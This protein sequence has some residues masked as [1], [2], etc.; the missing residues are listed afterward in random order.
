[1]KVAK[2][3]PVFMYHH[4]S[5]APGLVTVSPEN[6][7]AQ[8]ESLSRTGWRTAGLDELAGFLKGYPVPDRTCILTFDD[9]YRDNYVHA[10]PVLAEFGMKA[11]LFLITG[12][13]GQGAPRALAMPPISHAKCMASATDG[14]FSEIMLRWSEAEQMAKAGTFEFH[15]HTHTHKRWDRMIPEV[16]ERLAQLRNDLI[17]SRCTLERHLGIT[18]PH[19]CWPQ[20]YYDSQYQQCAQD[21]GFDYLY[22]TNKAVVKAGIDPLAIGRVVTKD[23][24]GTWIN[25]RAKLYSSPFLGGLY[26]K[27]LNL[28]LGCSTKNHKNTSL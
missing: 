21:V 8:I 7:R 18:T 12:W 4:V 24:P 23:R 9:G 28:K 17:T 20:G 25:H 3:L 22:T 13:I 11:V 2:A 26:I 6:F 16:E 19:L 5:P 15:S 10:H 27:S 1:M 14:E